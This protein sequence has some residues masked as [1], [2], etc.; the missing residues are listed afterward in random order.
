MTIRSAHCVRHKQFNRHL[1]NII[2]RQ[3]GQEAAVTLTRDYHA[4][5]LRGP[6]INFND[7]MMGL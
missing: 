3:D 2:L 6:V 1:Y 4:C 7:F 5:A